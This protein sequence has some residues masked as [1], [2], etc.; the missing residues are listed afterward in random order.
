[1]TEMPKEKTKRNGSRN[2]NHTMMDGN[3]HQTNLSSSGRS[4]TTMQTFGN[5][6]KDLGKE[7]GKELG[8]E[9]SQNASNS[10]KPMKYE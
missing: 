8:K 7:H 5:L 4:N 6:G 10:R 9:P 1:M 2:P 3:G